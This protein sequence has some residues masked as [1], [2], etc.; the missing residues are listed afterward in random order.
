M[1][2][3]QN[4]AILLAERISEVTKVAKCANAKHYNWLPL[5]E[6]LTNHDVP[7]TTARDLRTIYYDFVNYYVCSND[8]CGDYFATPLYTLRS[9][10]EA[11]ADMQSSDGGLL[12]F[13]EPI[14]TSRY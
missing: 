14:D 10:I 5:V 12:S 1:N 7:A 11:I 9:I 8:C 3:S 13:V 4:D 6:F 2:K